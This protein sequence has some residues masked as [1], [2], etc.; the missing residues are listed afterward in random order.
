MLRDAT[1]NDINQI[2][3]LGNLL[4]DNFSKV[5]NIPEMLN[6]GYSKIIVYEKEGKII[7]FISATI[8]YDTCDILDLIVAKEYQ[9][10]GVASNLISYLISDCPEYL[11]LITLEV[12][13]KNIPAIKLYEKFGFEIVYRR[14]KYY[15]DDDAYLMARKSDE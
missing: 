12:A 9:R 4:H 10:Q 8:L 7:G 3:E 2:N 6:D 14:E 11:K 15:K 5:N 13:S 1:I